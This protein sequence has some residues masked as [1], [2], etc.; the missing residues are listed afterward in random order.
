MLATSR[1][2]QKVMNRL[3]INIYVYLKSAYFQSVANEKI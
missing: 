3:H 1:T 2:R